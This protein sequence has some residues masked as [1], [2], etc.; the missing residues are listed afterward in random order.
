MHV[1]NVKALRRAA[2]R[3][4]GFIKVASKLISYYHPKAKKGRPYIKRKR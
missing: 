1:T 4:H 2:R 3:A